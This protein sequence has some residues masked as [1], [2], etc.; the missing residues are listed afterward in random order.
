MNTQEIIQLFEIY[1]FELQYFQSYYI[2]YKEMVG[3]ISNITDQQTNDPLKDE[4]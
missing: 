3:N 1:N 4:K 2:K